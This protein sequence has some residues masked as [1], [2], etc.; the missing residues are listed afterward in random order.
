[1]GTGGRVAYVIGSFPVPSQRFILREI[2]AVR[3]LGAAVEVHAIRRL[4]SDWLSAEERSVLEAVVPLP[5]PLSWRSLRAHAFILR[6]HPGRY[7]ATLGMLLGLPCRRWY[8]RF[9]L[10]DAFFRAPWLARRLEESGP[11]HVHAHFALRATEVAMAVAGLSGG[12]YSFTAHAYDIYREPNALEEKIRGAKFVVTCTRANAAYLQALCPEVPRERI[13]VVYHGVER[14]APAERPASS[15][16]RGVPLILSAGR[17]I[18]KKGFDTLIAACRLLADRG[19]PFRVEIAGDGPLRSR[20]ATQIREAGL[21]RHVALPG[22]RPYPD[23]LARYREAAVFALPSRIADDGD[24]DGIPNVV[25]EAMLWE[26]PVVS[27]AVSA[28]PEVVRDGVTG[29]LVPPDDAMA[30]AEA[31]Q[32]ALEDRASA[33]ARS[34]AARELVLREFNPATNAARLLGLF[35]DSPEPTG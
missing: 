33:A 29:W 25:L 15:S 16:E 4:P 11:S 19:I 32:S 14:A 31:L 13:A 2:M 27:T 8:L 30:S 12:S 34:R 20:L 35:P 21:E 18:P 6:R 24:R 17:L 10:L 9:R 26:V 1:M 23:L 3:A 22:W 28:I 7:V 5:A